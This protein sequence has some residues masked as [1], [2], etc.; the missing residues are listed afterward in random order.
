M[1]KISVQTKEKY[2]ILIEKGIIKDVP[3]LIMPF[4]ET[5]RVL[6]ITDDTVNSLYGKSLIKNLEDNGF[7][8]K[9]FAFENGEK[10]KNIKTLSDILEFALENGF[11]RNDLFLALGG[12][13][14]GD[15]TGLAAALF[16]RGVNVI[17]IPTTLLSAVDSSVGGKTAVNLKNGKNSVGVFK[18][19]SL[20]I[21][22]TDIIAN[23]PEDIF[24]EGMGEVIKYSVI[25]KLKATDFI[26][27][28]TVKENLEEIISD[29]LFLKND[30]VKQDEFDKDGIRNTLNAGHT[31]AHAIEILSHYTVPHGKAVSMGLVIESKIALKLGICDEKTAETIEN[32]VK[33][34][35]NFF[36]VDYDKKDFANACLKDKK[37]KD[38][39]IV[40]LLPERLGNCKEVKLDASSLIDLL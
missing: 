23:L 28:G 11:R 15:I 6:V 9:K 16:M 31:A 30:I 2:E 40:F 7:F 19:P 13:V 26:L 4:C 38:S 35:N 27:N 39:K 18:Q 1:R 25:K 37:N 32:S 8:A 33:K 29:C 12:G 34:C 21:I 36:F 20:V 14:V 24:S 3:R 10:S 22:D 5:K 17:Q